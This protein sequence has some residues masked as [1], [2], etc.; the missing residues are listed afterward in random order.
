[1]IFFLSLII[2]SQS[3]YEDSVVWSILSFGWLVFY[4]SQLPSKGRR[5]SIWQTA[6]NAMAV[7]KKPLFEDGSGDNSVAVSVGNPLAAP[8]TPPSE[9]NAANVEVKMPAS[10]A[11]Q[12]PFVVTY[13]K[14]N[15]ALLITNTLLLMSWISW[16]VAKNGGAAFAAFIAWILTGFTLLV[17]I[18]PN[19]TSHGT[20][21]YGKFGRICRSFMKGSLFFFTFTSALQAVALAAQGS[22][23]PPPG[24]LFDVQIG[25]YNTTSVVHIWCEGPFNAGPTVWYEHGWTGS[26]LDFSR[27]MSRTSKWTRRYVL[28][29]L[30]IDVHCLF[31]ALLSNH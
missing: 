25:L 23:Y 22:L 18:S 8:L 17:R 21:Q 29:P 16:I 20:R 10:S 5:G 27:V 31:L 12:Q 19:D 14:E 26:S 28:Y 4:F 1:M 6:D 9:K 15:W 13:F 2:A 30:S 24:K 7:G 11:S 3:N